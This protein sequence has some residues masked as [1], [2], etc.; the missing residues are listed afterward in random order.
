MPK[1]QAEEEE[2]E[3]NLEEK[4]IKVPTGI[5]LVKHSRLDQQ[6]QRSWG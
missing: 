6:T 3:R 1:A 2:T 4:K 5:M